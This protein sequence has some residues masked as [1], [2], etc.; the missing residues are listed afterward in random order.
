CFNYCLEIF[1]KDNKEGN[2]LYL[3]FSHIP[4]CMLEL[5]RSYHHG[6]DLPQDNN[7]E[8]LWLNKVINH[9]YSTNKILGEA[10]NFLGDIYY[11]G[12]VFDN[13]FANY[14]KS[15]ILDNKK[16]LYNIGVMYDNEEY[17]EKDS[18]MAIKCFEKVISFNLN[19]EITSNSM[20]NI[21]SIYR[22]MDPPNYQSAM[23]WA[24]KSHELGNKLA[25]NQ[26]GQLY[27]FGN[28]VT[29][30]I[31]EAIKHYKDSKTGDG[32]WNL[33]CIYLEQGDYLRSIYM[34][35][36]AQKIYDSEYDKESCEQRIKM[37]IND[38]YMDF[39]NVIEDNSSDSNDDEFL[40]VPTN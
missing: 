10:M 21:A 25:T 1:K 24:L 17:I 4:F 9:P 37:I 28:G 14:Q 39:A 35:K 23:N 34:V 12:K 15:Y 27:H 8:I 36:Q 3:T 31:N 16:S 19:N 32:Y 13:A 2:K 18:N 38:H 7:Q 26:I 6:Y 20:Y 22:R 30:D 29:K 5:A 11:N 33:S 40:I